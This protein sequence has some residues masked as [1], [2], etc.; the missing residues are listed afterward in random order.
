[1]TSGAGGVGGSANIGGSSSVNVDSLS[2]VGRTG[3]DAP[4]NAVGE[5]QGQ[6]NVGSGAEGR[7]RSEVG[8]AGDP[9]VK[10]TVEG[11]A[12]NLKPDEVQRTESKAGEVKS[13]ADRVRNP[14]VKAEVSG[15]VGVDEQVSTASSVQSKGA[16]VRGVAADPSG[17][18]RS[19]ASVAGEGEIRSHVPGEV[20]SAKGEVDSAASTVRD[21]K[22]AAESKARA[23][24]QADVRVDVGTK[25]DDPTK[26]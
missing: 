7:L 9:N 14:D 19:R 16:E 10:G 13:T 25:P 6:S 1:V 4:R 18:V 12:Q 20:S 17:T 3:T 21:P 8:P 22:A 26:K 5:A 15:R 23:E 11:Q 24:V 2:N